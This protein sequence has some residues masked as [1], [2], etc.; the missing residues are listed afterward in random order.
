MPGPGSRSGRVGEQGFG[1]GIRGFQRGNQK[2]DNIGNVNK[3]NNKK[4]KYINKY[5]NE[6]FLK[7]DS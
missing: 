2:G 7:K 3:E 6:S 5:I 1:E 4:A